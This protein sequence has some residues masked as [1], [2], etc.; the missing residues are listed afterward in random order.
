MT[1][2]VFSD[3]QHLGSPAF[4]AALIHGAQAAAWEWGQKVDFDLAINV[5]L[6][7]SLQTASAGAAVNGA[8]TVL[9][10]PAYILKY[11]DQNSDYVPGDAV[12]SGR[13]AADYPLLH[14]L[15]H[16]LGINREQM[17]PWLQ[18]RAG[19][20]YFM[21][22]GAPIPL[23]SDGYR[24]HL[25]NGPADG[26]ERDI[27]SGTAP[28]R[29]FEQIISP[30]DL[31]ILTTGGRHLAVPAPAHHDDLVVLYQASLGR[32]PDAAGLAYW[33]AQVDAGMTL[34]RIA[35]AFMAQPEAQALYGAK[36]TEALVAA[37]YQQALGH[38]PDAAGSAYWV[39]ELRAHRVAAGAFVEA[40]IEGARGADRA[41][42]IHTAHDYD[43]SLV[44]VLTILAG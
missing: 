27:M 1:S 13:D 6:S 31:Q 40:V 35:E 28:N 17:A 7:D 10:N 19:V 29:S 26:L 33:Q 3:P 16:A 25:G 22:G 14:E 11:V 39:A 21:G 12:A 8:T 32:A 18:D 44:G 36:S 37:V 15:G 4:D 42:L 5:V 30:Q 20:T 24:G 2:I 23:T 43:I 9:V 34:G 38:A 41:H